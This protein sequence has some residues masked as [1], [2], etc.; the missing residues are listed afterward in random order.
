[1]AITIACISNPLSIFLF[2]ATI[3]G[4]IKINIAIN[5][6]LLAFRT[7]IKILKI[8]I[9]FTASLRNNSQCQLMLILHLSFENY[10]TLSNLPVVLPA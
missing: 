6:S 1:M 8:K 2:S 3:N 5:L 4:G 9:R 10:L 7:L